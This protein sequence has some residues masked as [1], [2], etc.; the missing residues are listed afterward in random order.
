MATTSNPTMV[1]GLLLGGALLLLYGLRLLSE[2][3]QR[4][5]GPRLQKA[6]MAL[7]QRPF[8]AFGVGVVATALTQ[9]SSATSSLLVELVNAELVP[10]TTAFVMILGTNVGSTLV[11]QLLAFHVTDYAI[12]IAGAG[13][14]LG[15]LT[16]HKPQRDLGQAAFGFGVILLGLAAL[17]VGSAPIAASPITAEVLRSLMGAPLVLALLGLLLA[18]AFA[19]SAAAIGL[20]LVLTASGALSVF[21]ALAL[22][23]GANIGS[24]LTALLTA[25]SRPSVTGRRLALL[26]TGTKSLGAAIALALLPLLTNLLARLGL[27]PVWQVALTHLIFNLALAAVFVPLA[28]PVTRL[29]TLLLPEQE[30]HYEQ[31]LGPRYLDPEAL[32][33][34][35]VALGQATREV[36]RMADIVTEML[37]LSMLAFEKPD[38]RVPERINELDD[39]LDQLN[40]AI[41][42]YLTQ[43]DESRLT[44]EQVQRELALLYIITDLEAI[45]DI[46]DR[47]MMRLARRKQRR[48][49]AFSEEGWQDLLNYH[50]EVTEALEQALAALA[51]QDTSLANDFFVRKAELSKMKRQLHL[52]HVRRLQSG[53]S[54]SWESSAIHLD[55]LNALSRVLSHASNIAH[56]VRGDL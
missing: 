36:L 12:P 22:L 50:D 41:K 43:L 54:P 10:L 2:A 9:S 52:R 51:S 44:R 3:M 14:A 30:N 34:P 55:L 18:L 35:A 26:H 31:Q 47:Q 16:Q 33:S 42:R 27:E 20:V 21:A 15:L 45:G 11:V 49:V 28:A 37:R 56:A 29:V 32:A 8:M 6:T 53:L 13:A 23:F 17:Q 48:Q 38:A 24:T 19:S 25:I 40:A 1:V 4:A 46:I 39:Q 5:A 7:A